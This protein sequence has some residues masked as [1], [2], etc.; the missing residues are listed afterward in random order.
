MKASR[1]NLLNQETKSDL[2]VKIDELLIKLN[3]YI[4]Y[5]KKQCKTK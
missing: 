3:G 4:N 1:R 2:S 5:L